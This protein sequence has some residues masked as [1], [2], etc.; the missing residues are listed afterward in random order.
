MPKFCG[1]AA[2]NGHGAFDFALKLTETARRCKILQ[3]YYC[4]NNSSILAT[5]LRVAGNCPVEP[6]FFFI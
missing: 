4:A 2:K 1:E 6:N 5:V 3:F